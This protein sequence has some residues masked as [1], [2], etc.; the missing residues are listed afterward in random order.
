MGNAI[1]PTLPGL[2]AERG[3]V[4]RFSTEILTATSGKEFRT[5]RMA[6]PIY[7]F[8]LPH[9]FLRETG[10]R[11]ELRT[12]EGFFLAR[13]GAWDSFLYTCPHDCETVEETFGIGDGQRNAFQLMRSYGEFMEPVQ[14]VGEI[15][16]IRRAGQLLRLGTDYT[17]SATGVVV[18]AATVPAGAELRWSGSFYFRC[19]FKQDDM[20]FDRFALNLYKAGGVAFLGTLGVKI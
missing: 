5:G 2:K 6:N 19:R 8:S 13:R 10:G 11:T 1:F 15:R 20:S 18:F 12:L 14:N 7:E 3:R 4:V 17:V 16:S 9:E